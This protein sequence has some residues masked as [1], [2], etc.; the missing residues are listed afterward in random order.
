MIDIVHKALK[1]CLSIENKHGGY[2]YEISIR[3]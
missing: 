3:P 2:I 1:V